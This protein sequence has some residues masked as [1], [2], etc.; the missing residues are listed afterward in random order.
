M[1]VMKRRACEENARK[2][3]AKAHSSQVE[4]Y[5]AGRSVSGIFVRKRKKT[6][7]PHATKDQKRSNV[8][9]FSP[10]A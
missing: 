6:E 9:S 4:K 8:W 10:R 3:Q 1:P 7:N 2:P 5:K